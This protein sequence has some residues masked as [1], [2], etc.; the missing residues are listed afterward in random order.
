M[1]RASGLTL[2]RGTKVLLDDAE[3]VVHPGE[4]V[5]IV[6]KNGAGKS[7]L[8]AL[9]TGALDLDAG[10]L[11][12]PAGWRIASV[13]Q[14]LHA[15][16]R[17]AREFVIDG[18]TPLRALQARRAELTD[19]QGTQIAEV[20]AALVEAGAWS[21]ASRA[22]QLLAGLGFK[23][24]EWTQPVA[25][26]S[27]GWRMRLALARAL[28]APSEL[29]L[30][31]EPTNHLDLDAMLW[32][33]KWLAA[34][35][36]TVMLISHDT[37]FL[38]AVAKSI[39]H[40]D[41]AKLVRYRGGYGDFLTQRAER[42][43]QTN[44]AY[45]RQTR[46]A[47]RL[48]GFI[49]RFKAK[50]SKAKQAQSR[51]KALARMQVLAPLHAEAGIDI[52]LPSPEQV[53]DP[54]LTLEHLSAGYTD[55]AGN[56]V[57]ILRDVTL[58]V[59]AG[60]RVGVLGANGAGKSTLI[61]TLAEELPVQAGERRASRGLAI[62]YF[63]QHQ[64]DMLDVDNTPLAHLARLSPET[65]EQELRNYLGGFGFSGDTVNSKVGPMS[66]GEKA[67][68]ALSLIVWQK[69]NLLL[70][71]E[72]SNHL[73]VETREALAAALAEFGGSMLLV[74]HDRH[75]LRTT[76]DSFWIVADGA[77]R[78]FDGDLEDYRDWL[79]ARNA[80]ERAE[81]ARENAENGEAVVDRKAQRRAEAE[82]RQRLSALR[83]PLEAKLAKVEAEM[84]KLRAKLQALDAVI[85]DPDLYSDARR[86]ERQK[87]MAEHGEHGKRMET[88]EEQWLELQG[89][90]EEIEQG[91][92]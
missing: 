55:A 36:G 23:P 50:A 21:A 68:L 12:L 92:A 58:M 25:S 84:E 81:A 62:G 66:G 34:Y 56:D 6:G 83:K 70:L 57:P 5:G 72:P 2:R 15:D 44:I 41:H 33:E 52:R 74:S 29:L 37:E 77:V 49:D 7:S 80:G 78:E 27:G 90:L 76:V 63:H 13:E 91:E 53:P 54:L 24:A 85:A 4:R 30:L 87:V 71:D 67:R 19:D 35:P 82:Q 1:I 40:F 22:E 3:F 26:F 60:S 73:D 17:P 61:K 8:F 43:R 75:L 45:E 89:S 51:V 16:D 65:R 86:A 20:E 69:P 79:A 32:L 10:N 59:R 39:L 18:D 9:L 88:L 14:E 38:D 64:L 47:A 48:Q 11:A 46:E 42:L 31:D 28:M